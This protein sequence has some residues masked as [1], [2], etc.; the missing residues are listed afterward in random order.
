MPNI[1]D[2]L[3]FLKPLPAFQL[4]NN[5]IKITLALWNLCFCKQ[6]S[7][8]PIIR[9][10]F[11]SSSF[12]LQNFKKKF[13]K[14]ILKLSEAKLIDHGISKKCSLHIFF[15]ILVIENQNFPCFKTTLLILEFC[16]Q[17]KFQI[18]FLLFDSRYQ[19]L[20]LSSY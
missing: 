1:T 10:H 8:I 6:S 16:L 5:L 14:I 18:F 12:K 4:K 3:F 7:D 15:V 11:I 2:L 17:M 19:N 20:H 13:S 9:A